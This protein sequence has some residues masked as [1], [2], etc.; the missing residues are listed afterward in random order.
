MLTVGVDVGSSA[1]KA[2][3]LLPEDRVAILESVE[4]QSF[5][6][7]RAWI[8][9]DPDDLWRAVCTTIAA[10]VRRLGR[11]RSQIR[12]VALS[13]QRGTVIPVDAKGRAIYRAVSWQDLRGRTEWGAI[14]QLLGSDFERITGLYPSAYWTL[15]KLVWFSRNEPELWR[16]AHQFAFVHGY[17]ARRLGCEATVED[18]T[19]A[20][21]SGLLDIDSRDWSDHIV[22]AI[23]LRRERFGMLRSPGTII[24]EVS[25]TACVATELPPGTHIVCGA[26]D[27]QAVAI[28]A[29]AI[30]PGSMVINV[31]TAGVVLACCP[32]RPAQPAAGVAYLVHV[33]PGR[34]QAEGMLGSAGSVF[35]WLA[36]LT[37]S[38]TGFRYGGS[39]DRGLYRQMDAEAALVPP[40]SDGLFILPLFSEFQTAGDRFSGAMIGLSLSHGRPAIARAIIE[41]T[42]FEV[43]RKLGIMASRGISARNIIVCGGA[44]QSPIWT[45]VLADVIGQPVTT[46]SHNHAGVL[47]VG[48]IAA[49]GIGAYDDVETAVRE[50]VRLGATCEP[51][52]AAT[53]Y[54]E[55]YLEYDEIRV[56]LVG[57]DTREIHKDREWEFRAAES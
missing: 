57:D 26:G 6:P 8:E 49:T 5:S 14:R 22:E 33:L 12:A 48:A 44:A 19:N 21:F 28:G 31:G 18:P 4:Y 1:V 24:G 51:S 32:S 30:G 27:Q 47:G 2:G 45:Q 36:S 41:G 13:V 16:T 20:S 29:G 15:P 54:E 50:W 42:A 10:L 39:I 34:V 55:L 25:Q 23:G 43:R 40:G 52:A 35:R 17:L 7:R 38:A 46:L 56:K 9:Q 3:A 11:R 37:K 53:R